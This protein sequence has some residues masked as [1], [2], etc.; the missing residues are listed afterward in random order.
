METVVGN[1]KKIVKNLFKKKSRD[2]INKGVDFYSSN[3]WKQALERHKAVIEEGISIYAELVGFTSG[4]AYIQKG[5]DYGCVAAPTPIGEDGLCLCNAA[6]KCENGKIGSATRCTV[7]ELKPQTKFVVYKITY[8]KPNGEFIVF[9]WQQLKDY[10]AKYGLEHVKE[11]YFGKMK[12]LISSAYE[13][14]GWGDEKEFFLKFLQESFN[15][16]KD[17]K[18]CVNKVPAEGIVVWKDGALNRYE[19]YKLKSKLFTLKESNEDE[20]NI[21]DAE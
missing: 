6:T 3:I 16:E 13:K 4:G 15:L 5:Y 12:D 11:F 18:Q 1:L 21:Q 2:W 10:C 19:V 17:C 14:Y 7:A 9:S 8:T 20:A